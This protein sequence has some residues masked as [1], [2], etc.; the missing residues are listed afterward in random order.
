MNQGKTK[1]SQEDIKHYEDIELLKDYLGQYIR[2]KRRRVQLERRLKAIC[3]EMASPVGG[4]G[5][6]PINRPK[7]QISEGAASFVI[8]KSEQETRIEEQ[9]AEV[10]K[11]LLKIMDVFDYLDKNSDE[12]NALE[13]HYIDNYKWE[14]VAAEMHTHR[15]T[16]LNYAKK[17]LEKLLTFKRVKTLLK[18][19]RDE[20][21]L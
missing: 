5:Y 15:N 19:Y 18:K 12:R 2:A 1:L 8:R 6:S 21:G 20:K 7:N 13:L 10:T 16:A 11:D 3:D 4:Q 17:G 9:K 14:R